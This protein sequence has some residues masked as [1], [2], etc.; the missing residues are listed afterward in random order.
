MHDKPARNH[1]R[2]LHA[3]IRSDIEARILSGEWPPGYRIPPETDLMREWHCSRMTV[4][5]A[6]AALAAQ[7]LVIR[8]KRAGTIVAR[9][10]IQAAVLNIPDIRAEAEAGGLRYGFQILS[11]EILEPC[12]SHLGPE[13]HHL[14]RNRFLRSLHS[15]DDQ[16]VMLEDRHIFLET[17]PLAETAD[18]FEVPPGSWLIAHV[19]W[20]EA[21]HRISAVAAESKTA[22]LL[23]VTSGA[24]CLLLERRTRRG[25]ET[26]TIVR[27][28]FRGDSFDL[29][30][31]FSPRSQFG[32]VG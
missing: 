24:A 1:P 26:V 32:P 27:Q 22:N 5:K 17:V 23:E 16:P 2:S 11:D 14:G 30:A 15:I 10:R 6:V 29:T 28:T 19:P 13:G 18:F 4:N 31:R 8:N 7:G 21:E 3:R 12:C 20:T 9:P 25:D